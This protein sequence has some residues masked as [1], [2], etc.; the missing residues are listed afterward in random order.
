MKSSKYLS[1]KFQFL[2]NPK[3]KEYS[4]ES[5]EL[6]HPRFEVR[7]KDEESGETS[8]SLLYLMYSQENETLFI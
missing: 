8:Q 5:N 3:T 4:L 7:E 2:T 1:E 6:T